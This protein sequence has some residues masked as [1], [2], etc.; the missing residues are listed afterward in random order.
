M[1]LVFI[2]SLKRRNKM[3][4]SRYTTANLPKLIDEIERY[5]LGF[6]TFFDRVSSLSGTY[7]TYPPVN[8]VQE[9]ETRR[10][11]E[12]ALAG[13]NSSELKVYAENGNLIV[14]GSKETKSTDTYIERGVAFRNFKWARVLP[15]TWR[16]D[17]VSFANGLLTVTINRYVPEHEKRQDYRF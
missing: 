13:F 17:N 14:E 9:S 5:A 10:R 8:I 3:T 15:E 1:G 11:V 4:I 7:T 2:Y 16:V 6:D 12:M